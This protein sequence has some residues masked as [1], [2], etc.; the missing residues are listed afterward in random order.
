MDELSALLE[1]KAERGSGGSVVNVY[2][3][4]T[5]SSSSSS[6]SLPARKTLVTAAAVGGGGGGR[7]GGGKVLKR[8]DYTPL[9]AW[10]SLK[11]SLDVGDQ[12]TYNSIRVRFLCGW[13]GG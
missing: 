2:A 7:G 5:S 10:R 12:V 1:F 8:Y 3:K 4:E 9:A 13:V 11:R 6:S